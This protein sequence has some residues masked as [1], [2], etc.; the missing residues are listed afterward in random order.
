MTRIFIF[1]TFSLLFSLTHASSHEEIPKNLED[2]LD[3]LDVAISQKDT[4]M[5]QQLHFIDSMKL[6]A[7][8]IAADSL[9][10]LC[11]E[12]G[13]YYR[14]CN[15]DSAIY[16]YDLGSKSAQAVHNDEILQ[17]LILS[18]ASILPLQGFIKEA[19][20]KYDSIAKIILPSNKI[21]LFE[22][23]NRLFN[24]ASSFYPIGKAN[25]YY[26][27]KAIAA[28][29]SLISLIPQDSPNAHLY[30]A[31][32]Y[33]ENGNR[34][35]MVAELAEIIDSTS[36]NELVFARAVSLMAE[37]YDK[38]ED[39]E[40]EKMYYLALASLS[41]I[42]SGTLEGTALQKLGAT[43][44][45][46]GDIS[47]AYKYLVL[48][49]DNAIK[50]GSRIRTLQSAEVYPIIAKSFKAQ[51]ETKLIWLTWLVITLIIALIIII[52]S[53]IYLRKKM[54]ILNEL[55]IRLSQANV[56]KDTY[57][58]Q[59]LSLSS[60]YIEKLEEFHRIAK[61]KLK[62]N[63]VS[64]LYELLDSKKM[65]DE[66]SQMFY[67]IF[68]NAFIHIYPTFINDVNNLLLPEK[69]FEFPEMK[70]NTELRILAFLR[71]GIDNSEQIAG[72]LGLSLNTIY[73]YR[74]RLKGRAINRESFDS[75]IMKIG[76]ID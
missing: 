5:Q 49:L 21:H 62:T 17:Q 65:L 31:Q 23:G 32:I 44:Y 26:S 18:Q 61:R 24:F 19:T 22:S 63:Q 14:R 64:E 43:L 33:A 1:L 54:I 27:R 30:K 35:L 29:D 57:I 74:N 7:N 68:D 41:D 75:D 3:M 73:T 11:K 10:H 67:K 6:K 48:S 39:K 59:F 20:E 52:F 40:S 2:A 13:D 58:S 45:N 4:Y 9:P 12:I 53:L 76:T 50:S 66:Q 25:Q 34:T 47:R 37:Y 69:R 36:I 72:F 46:S 60:I 28:T 55:K 71:L 16:Y 70:L 38:L 15:I 56:T 51:D 8:N 42:Y